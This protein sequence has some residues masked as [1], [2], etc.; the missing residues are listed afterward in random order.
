[1]SGFQN[2]LNKHLQQMREAS[3]SRMDQV[4]REQVDPAF[5]ESVYTLD[6]LRIEAQADSVEGPAQAERRCFWFR[7]RGHAAQVEFYAPRPGKVAAALTMHLHG[8]LPDRSVLEDRLI[9]HVNRRW[10]LG[11]L[12]VAVEA[13]RANVARVEGPSA[14]PDQAA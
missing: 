13:L 11:V 7:L 10:A 9:D 8:E 14:N 3:T 4:L 1:M 2:R 12:Q 6:T 5:D